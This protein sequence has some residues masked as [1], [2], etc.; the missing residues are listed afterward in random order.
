M[1]RYL[2]TLEVEVA[3]TDCTSA[4]QIMS[5]CDFRVDLKDLYNMDVTLVAVQGSH[6]EDKDVWEISPEFE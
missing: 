6:P 5:S 2:I 4:K 3:E 1:A